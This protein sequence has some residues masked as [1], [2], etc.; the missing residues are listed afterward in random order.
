MCT[1]NTQHTNTQASPRTSTGRPFMYPGLPEKGTSTCDWSSES[2]KFNRTNWRCASWLAV[3]SV[4]VKATEICA[5]VQTC[6]GH[7]CTCMCARVCACVCV[8]RL[9]LGVHLY[10]CVSA[11]AGSHSGEG[12]K[13][14]CVMCD[15]CVSCACVRCTHVCVCV[16]V[17]VCV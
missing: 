3:T 10:I 12:S 4:R 14:L 2:T 16:C 5:R 15:A 17:C 1:H 9:T 11:L 13:C 6:V 8:F 7:V